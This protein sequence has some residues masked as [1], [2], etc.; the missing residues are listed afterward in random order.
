VAEPRESA[1][2]I[3]HA[4]IRQAWVG[5]G[6]FVSM[7][8]KRGLPVLCIRSR[9]RMDILGCYGNVRVWRSISADGNRSL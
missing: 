6:V 2:M 3:S 1:S 7:V 4:A 8:Y 9:L 5:E